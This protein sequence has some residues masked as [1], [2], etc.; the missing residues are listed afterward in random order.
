MGLH[1]ARLS[2]R[3]RDMP[4]ACAEETHRLPLTLPLLY[5][6]HLFVD[7]TT[8]LWRKRDRLRDNTAPAC[9][10][11]IPPAYHTTPPRRFLRRRVA[12]GLWHDAIHLVARHN[13]LCARLCS[14]GIKTTHGKQRSLCRRR[15]T[16]AAPRLF[17][18]RISPAACSAAH[19]GR[20]RDRRGGLSGVAGTS[21]RIR[22]R[23][24]PFFFI[25]RQVVGWRDING[26]CLTWR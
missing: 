12:R 2:W 18:S 26:C 15:V 1:A 17:T 13:S 23:R 14:G 9:A 5:C 3:I 20:W 25:G 10:T 7:A 21:R 4:R 6:R 19:R 11:T 8:P 24:H 22:L 16:L